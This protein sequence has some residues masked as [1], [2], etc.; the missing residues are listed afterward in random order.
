ML[1]TPWESMIGSAWLGSPLLRM[2]VAHSSVNA[3]A[4]L[5][6][7]VVVVL[8]SSVPRRVPTLVVVPKLATRGE[9][10][11]PPL[12]AASAEATATATATSPP[13]RR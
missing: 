4:L 12:H 8:P 2:Q 6:G 9:L 13:N 7:T 5:L 10:E 11:P 1:M 3:V